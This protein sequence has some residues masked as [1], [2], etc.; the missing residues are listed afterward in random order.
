[1][2]E[3]EESD[4]KSLAVEEEEGGVPVAVWSD[5]GCS[6][7][8]P[9]PPPP[10]P[11][12]R[13]ATRPSVKVFSSLLSPLEIWKRGRRRRRQRLIFTH[14]HKKERRMY[15]RRR[16]RRFRLT[17]RERKRKKEERGIFLS[18]FPNVRNCGVFLLS[19]PPSPQIVIACLRRRWY[20]RRATYN[21]IDPIFPPPTLLRHVAR[22]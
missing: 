20:K 14:T 13:S 7:P 5:C 6:H 9:P 8:P 22:A 4:H 15:I 11:P 17:K 19:R 3:T 12:L 18:L 1:M 21:S 16:R 10:F 2:W